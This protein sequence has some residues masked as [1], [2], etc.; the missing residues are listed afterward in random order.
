MGS[1]LSMPEGVERW[2]QYDPEH[3]A[4][5]EV[6][7]GIRDMA[8]VVAALRPRDE[9]PMAMHRSAQDAVDAARHLQ[10]AVRALRR[11]RGLD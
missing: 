8:Q 9:E 1:S 11:M 2:L 3:W 5:S 6:P 10:D 7:E 4:L